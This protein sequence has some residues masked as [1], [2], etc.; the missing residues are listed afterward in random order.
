MDFMTP[1]LFTLAII[2]FISYTTITKI[3]VPD[4]SWFITG[5]VHISLTILTIWSLFATKMTDPGYVST[6]YQSEKQ[7]DLEKVNEG[8]LLS[9]YQEKY[10]LT[11]AKEPLI[12]KVV[13]VHHYR[14][15]E[16]EIHMTDH[17]KVI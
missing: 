17:P 1:L 6:Q 10:I 2:L 12:K 8:N 9:E 4:Q 11:N 14:D 7:E 5:I 15:D 13:D 16:R 3:I